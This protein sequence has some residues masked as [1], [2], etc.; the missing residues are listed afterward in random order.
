MFSCKEHIMKVCTLRFDVYVLILVL[1]AFP[2]QLWETFE[3]NPLFH[4]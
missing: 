4:A 3:A 1:F 2:C